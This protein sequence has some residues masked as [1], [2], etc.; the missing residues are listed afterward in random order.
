MRSIFVRVEPTVKL[1]HAEEGAA[2]T[3]TLHGLLMFDRRINL[4]IYFLSLTQFSKATLVVGI[5]YLAHALGG[6]KVEDC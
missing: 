6:T 1:V 4:S 2:S 5:L 3:D